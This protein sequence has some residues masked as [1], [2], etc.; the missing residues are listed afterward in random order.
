MS[1][2]ILTESDLKLLEKYNVT[3]DGAITEAPA[4]FQNSDAA[5]AGYW[6]AMYKQLKK[7]FDYY[8][9]LIEDGR[10]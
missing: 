2:M 4:H 6:Y 1:K 10:K 7:E 8:K 9:K 3:L 5:L